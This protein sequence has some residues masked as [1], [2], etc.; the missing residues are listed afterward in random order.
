MLNGFV[1]T[2]TPRSV[3][4]AV[5]QTHDRL[6]SITKSALERYIRSFLDTDGTNRSAIETVAKGS[7]SYITDRSL[8]PKDDVT[9]RAT[10]LARMFNEIHEEVPAI[11]IIDAG[12]Q[13]IP[14]G[15][16]SGLQHSTLD[17][18]KWQ[19]WFHKH[20]RI[21]L[22]I[23]TLTADQESTDQLMEIIE[24]QFNNLRNIA[25]GSRITGEPGEPGEAWEVRIPL[26]IGISATS[27]V[28][29]TDDPKDQ[30]WFANF[31]ITVDAEDSFAIE[32]PFDL[33][34]T[35]DIGGRVAQGATPGTSDLSAALP[36]VI[37]APTTIQI[38]SPTSVGFRRLRD[39]QRVI[40]DQPRVATIDPTTNVITPRRLGTFKLQVI[41]LAV[42]Q[43]SGGPRALAPVVIVEQSISVTL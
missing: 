1:A 35:A 6:K 11:L 43:D 23:A 7:L 16:N 14:S 20:F 25:G 36:P 29:I 3:V 26:E 30:L 28:N 9:R 38:T 32:M 17:G 37:E 22:T 12:M 8:D 31:D 33:D 10:Q 2:A 41:D 42:R 39:T 34:F 4:E 18:G 21:P 40:I 19:G 5:A 15:L 24:L 27:G 13:S